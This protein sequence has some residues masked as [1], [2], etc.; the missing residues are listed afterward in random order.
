MIRRDGEF[1][2]P[3]LDLSIPNAAERTE[4]LNSIDRV[5]QHGRFI[6][7]PEVAEFE[8]VIAQYCKRT[9]AVGVGS[10]TDAIFLALK[11]LGIGAGDHVITSSISWLASATTIA[12]TGAIPVFADV[13]EDLN[14]NVDS[15]REN[16]N[17]RTK[18]ILAVDYAGKVC[19]VEALRA[20]AEEHGIPLIEDA[21]QAF[22]ALRNGAPAGANS[23]MAVFSLNPMKVL[24]AMGEAGIVLTDDEILTERLKSLR[25]HGMIDRWQTDKL[26]PNARMDTIQAAI[27]L[28]RLERVENVISAR[29]AIAKQYNRAL[30]SYVT[31]PQQT[32]LPQTRDAWFV[33]QIRTTERDKLIQHLHNLGIEAL[34]R[35]HIALPDQPVF[36]SY[37]SATTKNARRI[38]DQ[39]LCL[40]LHENLTKDDVNYVL[41]GVQSFFDGDAS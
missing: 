18:A 15:V 41:E 5:M 36:A 9:F 6:L 26:G 35:E 23:D 19:Q 33:Y 28:K 3:F 4:Y 11:V 12:Q 1:K 24:P 2:V 20:I 8:T 7:G 30:S 34:L 29:T 25:Y 10:G 39:L 31:I 38:A 22:G 14:I 16:L 27:L 37:N 21:S 17:H 32:H 13:N 40:P